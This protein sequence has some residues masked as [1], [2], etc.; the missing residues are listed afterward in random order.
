MFRNILSNST[1]L[2]LDFYV[3]Y[4]TGKNLNFNYH[5][6]STHIKFYVK[7]SVNSRY[8]Y[9]FIYN[10]DDF[11]NISRRTVIKPLNIFC[12]ILC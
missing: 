4:R 2:N 1:N 6:R 7:L 9:K 12:K 5:V 3:V 8:V 10:K 11:C